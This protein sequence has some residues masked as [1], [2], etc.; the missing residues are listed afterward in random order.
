MRQIFQIL[1]SRSIKVWSNV[2]KTYIRP[3][4]EYASVIWSPKLKKHIIQIEKVQK[5]FTRVALTKCRLPYISYIERLKFFSLDTLE[6]RRIVSDLI[7]AYKIINNGTSLPKESLFNFSSR[8]SRKHPYQ[9]IL[10]K[11]SSKCA[12]SFVN[13]TS[14]R[15]NSLKNS[16]VNIRNLNLFRKKLIEEIRAI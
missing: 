8:P 4:I 5:L 1:K 12:N 10:R 13:R 11:C 6:N 2:F 15:W 14:A 9:I 3:L 7:M 16:T